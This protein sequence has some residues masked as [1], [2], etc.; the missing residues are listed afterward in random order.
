MAE[1]STSTGVESNVVRRGGAAGP[2]IL[3]LLMISIAAL[4]G[5]VGPGITASAGPPC[6]PGWVL[7]AEYNNSF[8]WEGS[9]TERASW[10]GSVRLMENLDSACS[11]LQIYLAYTG[12]GTGGTL[13]LLGYLIGVSFSIQNSTPFKLYRDVAI[14]AY[15]DAVSWT[16]DGYYPGWYAHIH[17]NINARGAEEYYIGTTHPLGIDPALRQPMPLVITGIQAV[18]SLPLT[19]RGY[20]VYAQMHVYPDLCQ[21]V[22]TP[23]PIP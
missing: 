9:P 1:P 13:G 10:T 8:R 21:C 2:R 7:V 11:V 14:N 4:A 6:Q 5:V 17:P 15:G 20:T 19:L 16:P 22:A 18:F 23:I 3:P 12:P